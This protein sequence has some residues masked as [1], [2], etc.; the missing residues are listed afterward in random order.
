MGTGLNLYEKGKHCA[1]R[2]HSFKGS[3]LGWNF[4]GFLLFISSIWIY[5][6]L[7]DDPQVTLVHPLDEPSR[8]FRLAQA[9]TLLDA[10][11]VTPNDAE[12]KV[13][14]RRWMRMWMGCMVEMNQ[15]VLEHF[16]REVFMSSIFPKEQGFACKWNI[17]KSQVIG[18][19][20]IR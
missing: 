1:H 12:K 18:N 19:M 4:R 17:Q 20:I 5:F 14:S 9:C 10:T 7:N 6:F 3:N 8:Q 11:K 16:C 15:K 2:S 13:S